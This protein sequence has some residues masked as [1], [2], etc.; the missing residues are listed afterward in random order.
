MTTMEELCSSIT[1]PRRRKLGVSIALIVATVAAEPP[2]NLSL[3]VVI[4]VLA[5]S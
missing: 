2:K 3:M 5:L 4:K 1:V